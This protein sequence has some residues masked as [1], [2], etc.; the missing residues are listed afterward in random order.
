MF[1]FQIGAIGRKWSR[2]GRQT[3]KMFQ[4]QIGAIG[5][6][7]SRE[8]RQTIKMFQFQIGAI[9]S[10]NAA[11]LNGLE[12]SFNSRLVRLAVESG[13]STPFAFLRFNSR[14]VRLAVCSDVVCHV[15]N[16][17]QFQIGAIGRMKSSL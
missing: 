9:G 15:A 14:L 2:E 5:R 4:F 1:Q 7:W 6:K 3:I 11:Y 17:F 13:E 10:A 8:G 12:Q 16:R